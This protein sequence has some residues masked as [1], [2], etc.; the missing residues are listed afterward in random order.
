[1]IKKDEGAVMEKCIF[2][3]QTWV[4]FLEFFRSLHFNPP[5]NTTSL[6][7]HKILSGPTFSLA[8]KEKG[9]DD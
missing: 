1:M 5:K 7:N 3:I 8:A 9:T 4:F 6:R 2:E